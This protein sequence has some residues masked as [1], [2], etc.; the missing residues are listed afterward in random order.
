MFFLRR[1]FWI[2]RTKDQPFG[3][4]VTSVI[5]R[6]IFRLRRVVGKEWWHE[7]SVLYFAWKTHSFLCIKKTKKLNWVQSAEIILKRNIFPFIIPNS[8]KSGAMSSVAL[9]AVFSLTLLAS[10]IPEKKQAAEGF[11]FG[12]FGGGGGGCGC[13]CCVCAFILFSNINYK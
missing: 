1:T 12:G 2:F 9:F 6:F 13:C 7:F 5:L 4:G 3:D 10:L 8:D 11:L